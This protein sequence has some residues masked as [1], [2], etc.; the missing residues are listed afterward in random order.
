MHAC[1]VEMPALEA[2]SQRTVSGGWS[3]SGVG[4]SRG[5]RGV[6]APYL[7]ISGS[8]FRSCSTRSATSRAGASRASPRVPR[9]AGRGG[10]GHGDRAPRVNGAEM[11]A[12]LE[13]RCPRRA[14]VALRRSGCLQP[15]R[16]GEQASRSCEWY[17]T[18]KRCTRGS[19]KGRAPDMTAQRRPELAVLAALIALAPHR[20]GCG[21]GDKTRRSSSCRMP[22]GIRAAG[23]SGSGKHCQA[24]T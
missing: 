18:G 16:E 1:T 2:L 6:L 17:R 23:D 20:A 19:G 24:L 7:T 8:R 9:E 15:R 10:G 14:D 22:P 13:T 5:P 12:L 11:R 4:G 21:G 3:S